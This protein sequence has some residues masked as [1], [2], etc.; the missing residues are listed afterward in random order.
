MDG[1]DSPAVE[2]TTRGLRIQRQSSH[3][4]ELANPAL[5]QILERRAA[6]AGAPDGGLDRLPE[7]FLDPDSDAQSIGMNPQP[8]VSLLALGDQIPRVDLEHQLTAFAS[9]PALELETGDAASP[10]IRV[11]LGDDPAAEEPAVLDRRDGLVTQVADVGH[12]GD[13]V[14]RGRPAVDRWVGAVPD[15]LD[16]GLPLDPADR[17]VGLGLEGRRG[18]HQDQRGLRPPRQGL[19]NWCAFPEHGLGAAGC[20]GDSSGRRTASPVSTSPRIQ[21]APTDRDGAPRKRV[22]GCRYP[23]S[24]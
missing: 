12:P 4:V 20:G 2:D 15:I 11:A 22:V 18:E 13:E 21:F 19:S 8:V 17:E 7:A 10:P 6:D 24:A 5:H 14:T 1:V 23:D 9:P 16:L 3:L